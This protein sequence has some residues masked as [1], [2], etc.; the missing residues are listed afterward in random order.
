VPASEATMKLIAILA[1]LAVASASAQQECSGPANIP[2]DDPVAAQTAMR[3]LSIDNRLLVNERCNVLFLPDGREVALDAGKHYTRV[4]STLDRRGTPTLLASWNRGSGRSD[5]LT[6]LG[7]VTASERGSLTCWRN[8]RVPIC[9]SNYMTCEC[10]SDRYYHC[11]HSDEKN[12]QAAIGRLVL[13][14]P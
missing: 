2:T 11:L 13:V 12:Q 14:P 5:P 7:F 6:P 9:T 3:L 1:T 4:S 10:Q 8:R